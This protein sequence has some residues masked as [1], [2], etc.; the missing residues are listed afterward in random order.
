ML[1]CLHKFSQYWCDSNKA[2]KWNLTCPKL[3]QLTNFSTSDKPD[4]GFAL[5]RYPRYKYAVSLWLIRTI[6]G[7]QWPKLGTWI[8]MVLFENNDPMTSSKVILTAK[9]QN[10][11]VSLSLYRGNYNKYA[12]WY[13]TCCKMAQVTISRLALSIRLRLAE[14]ACSCQDDVYY[15]ETY[16]FI[17]SHSAHEGVHP[18]S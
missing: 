12:A 8:Y 16:A 3:R 18:R 4:E 14:F 15:V 10:T 7:K 5:I 1:Y 2:A 13:E 11:G 6:F 17:C 9:M